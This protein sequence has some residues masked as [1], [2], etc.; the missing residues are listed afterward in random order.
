MPPKRSDDYEL[1]L[2]Q[3]LEQLSLNP[4][5]SIPKAAGCYDVA[6]RTLR[7][8][9]NKGRQNPKIAHLHECILNPAQEQALVKWACFQD[10]R[11]I[12]PCLDLLKD[13]A[14]A[15]LQEVKPREVLG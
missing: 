2:Q 7:D 6:V 3:A 9:K 12:P 11:G 14:Q 13:K 10:D 15:I 5:L 1:R 8:R 4:S